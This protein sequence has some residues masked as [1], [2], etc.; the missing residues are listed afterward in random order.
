MLVVDFSRQN[1][2][3]ALFG[4]VLQVDDVGILDNFFALGGDSLRSAQIATRIGA[5][6]DCV[7]DGSLLFR[8]PTVAELAAEIEHVTRDEARPVAPPIVALPRRA[9]P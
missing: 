3:A 8:R 2:V 6:F 1:A 7:I 9:Q 5:L 4:D